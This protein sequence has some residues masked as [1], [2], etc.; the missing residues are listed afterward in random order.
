MSVCLS[1]CVF[2]KTIWQNIPKRGKYD[3]GCVYDWDYDVYSLK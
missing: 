3:I 1:V 2:A